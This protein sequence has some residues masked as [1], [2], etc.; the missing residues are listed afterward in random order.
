MCRLDV[1]RLV[2]TKIK[3]PQTP[4]R[5]AAGLAMEIVDHRHPPAAAR[6]VF[7]SCIRIGM[8]PIEGT[9]TMR[10]HFHLRAVGRRM[11]HIERRLETG[12]QGQRLAAQGAD[13]GAEILQ[14]ARPPHHRIEAARTVVVELG[15]NEARLGSQSIGQQAGG[16]DLTEPAPQNTMRW[17]SP[18]EERS[19][20]HVPAVGAFAGAGKP[21]PTRRAPDADVRQ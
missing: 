18:G 14:D 15:R 9:V 2:A 3:H 11:W 13:K 10:H 17:K 16:L 20:G 7:V 1:N 5:E 8:R 12:L 4:T 21:E 6:R 19:I